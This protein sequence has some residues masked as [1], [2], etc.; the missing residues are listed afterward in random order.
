MHDE[1]PSVTSMKSL[2][3]KTT[4][5]GLG[6]S[7]L[8]SLPGLS[9]DLGNGSVIAQRAVWLLSHLLHPPSIT[10][11]FRSLQCKLSAAKG[12]GRMPRLFLPVALFSPSDHR[13]RA[14]AFRR[15]WH[16]EPLQPLKYLSLLPSWRS[17]GNS[18]PSSHRC[19][20]LKMNAD[21][22]LHWCFQNTAVS[23]N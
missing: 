11:G 3:L 5:R 16:I 15:H 10:L 8:I 1:N 22:E 21:F 20:P 9:Q 17:N 6:L 12:V 2:F 4:H 14:G 23:L 13:G 7:V 19:W 18:L